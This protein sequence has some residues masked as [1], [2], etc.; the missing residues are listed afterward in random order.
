MVEM[1]QVLFPQL[2]LGDRGFQLGAMLL[3]YDI[4]VVSIFRKHLGSNS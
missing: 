3:S 4:N 1:S 2:R